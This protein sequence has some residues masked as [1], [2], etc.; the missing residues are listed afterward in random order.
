M[1]LPEEPAHHSRRR[2]FLRSSGHIR[3]APSRLLLPAVRLAT[4]ARAG[5]FIAD[6]GPLMAAALARA[7]PR[8]DLDSTCCRPPGHAATGRRSARAKV[9]GLMRPPR[10]VTH[11]AFRTETTRAI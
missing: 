1:G 9:V 6:S 2:R 7:L 4:G 5:R 10:I 8:G 3:P 11:S